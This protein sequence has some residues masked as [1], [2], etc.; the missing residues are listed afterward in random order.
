MKPLEPPV[1]DDCVRLYHGTTDEAGA[2]IMKS[3]FRPLQVHDEVDVIAKE[4][5]VSADDILRTA[6]PSF[7]VDTYKDGE[8]HISVID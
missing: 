3:G 4:F 6:T 1:A 2:S 8:D 7:L 5:G